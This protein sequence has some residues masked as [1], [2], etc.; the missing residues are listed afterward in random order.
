MNILEEA[1]VITSEDRQLVYGRPHINHNNTAAL[2]NAYL[3]ARVPAEPLS[4][5]D[6]C[7]LNI[8]QKIARLTHS[9]EHR[10]TLIDIAGYARNIE[11]I[12][13]AEEEAENSVP[14]AVV[15]EPE[16][17][18][19]IYVACPYTHK[20]YE[21]RMRRVHSATE[22]TAKLMRE[23]HAVYSPI[24]HGHTIAIMHR[25]PQDHDFWMRQC[26]P[27]VRAAAEL[28]VLQEPGWTTSK[29]VEAEMAEANAHGIPIRFIAT[30][31][32]DAEARSPEVHRDREH[33]GAPLW[34]PDTQRGVHQGEGLERHGYR[35]GDVRDPAPGEVSPEPRAVVAGRGEAP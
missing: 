13:D 10:D 22:Y 8:L 1:A 35:V 17:A 30:R 21:V 25:V 6:V 3:A 2:W 14:E 11:M 9:P 15:P 4:N 34:M 31:E 27:M 29:G 18:G 32:A 19:F 5:V 26:L 28:H 33:R 24:T 16:E 23:G 7:V 20:D 12:Y